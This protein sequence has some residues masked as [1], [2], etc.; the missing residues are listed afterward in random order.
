M[1]WLLESSDEGLA[2]AWRG[3]P[4]FRGTLIEIRRWGAEGDHITGEGVVRHVLAA[5]DD[6]CVVGVE[7]RQTRSFPPS[8][9]DTNQ[10]R[11][12]SGRAP[13]KID[14]TDELN[15]SAHHPDDDGEHL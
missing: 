3:A 5:H 6:L 13:V 1:G 4:P 9:D 14:L 11:P 15:G 10:E 12:I 7:L 2:F 8:G